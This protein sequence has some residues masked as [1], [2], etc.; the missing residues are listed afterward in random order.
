MQ[1]EWVVLT[2]QSSAAGYGIFRQSRSLLGPTFQSQAFSKGIGASQSFEVILTQNAT[3]ASE[4]GCTQPPR[5]LRSTRK[6]AAYDEIDR[7]Y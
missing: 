6:E 2:E 3:H 1:R 7:R 4:R 5:F